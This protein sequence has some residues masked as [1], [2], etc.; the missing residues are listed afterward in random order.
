MPTLQAGKWWG[1]RRLADAQGRFKMVA[2]DQRTPLMQPIAELRGL[3]EAPYDD[4]ARVKEAIT[5][6]LSPHASAVLLDPNYGYPSSIAA[7]PTQVGL[8]LSLEH[9]VTQNSPQGRRTECI[10]EW[11]VEKIRRI[12]GDAVKFLVWY[13]PDAD[14]KIR[15]H[16]QAVVKSVGQE[17]RQHDIVMLLELLV[18]PLPGEDPTQ[19]QQHRAQLVLDSVRDFAAP[20][21]GVDIYKLEPP[22]PH[23][24]VA[25]P[26]GK[27]AITAQ[28]LFDQMGQMT[29][30]PWVVLSAG[31]GPDDFERTLTYAYRAGASGYLCGRAIWQSAFEHF[32]YF[33][34]MESVLAQTSAPYV[35]RLNRL[36][37]DLASPWNTHPCWGKGVPALPPGPKF[38]HAYTSQVI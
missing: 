16:Q 36:T 33:S 35:D 18:Y 13:R 11:S 12:G 23:T 17:C 9:H 7:M 25:D 15:A 10:P 20:E 27:E 8:C 4:L 26:H 38:A 22:A 21:F 5:R 28:A 1:M 19:V 3:P 29:P 30:K 14:A 2:I 34:R 24:G 32:P 6:H 31:A 37:D